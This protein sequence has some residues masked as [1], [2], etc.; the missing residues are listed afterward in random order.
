VVQLGW[1]DCLCRSG[2]F[3]ASWR[4]ARGPAIRLKGSVEGAAVR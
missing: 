3:G 1:A 4:R 2:Q